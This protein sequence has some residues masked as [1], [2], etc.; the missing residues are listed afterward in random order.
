MK[1]NTIMSL[2]FWVVVSL[3]LIVLFNFYPHSIPLPG[4]LILVPTL[5]ALVWYVRRKRRPS[6]QVQSQVPSHYSA[7]NLVVVGF[8][9]FAL[10]IAWIVFAARYFRNNADGL[11]YF[12]IVPSLATVL[13]GGLVITI[14]LYYIVRRD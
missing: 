6:Q 13:L 9:M 7:K 8:V 10:A 11:F 2:A 5:F 4:A 3:L 14:G 12:V 1:G